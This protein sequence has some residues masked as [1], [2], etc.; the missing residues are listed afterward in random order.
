ML[1][2]DGIVKKEIC[3]LNNLLIG[4]GVLSHE[5]N[6]DIYIFKDN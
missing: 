6:E 2:L 1:I 4:L 3:T 5:V